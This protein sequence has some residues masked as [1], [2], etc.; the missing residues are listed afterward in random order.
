MPRERSQEDELEDDWP[1]NSSGGHA[2]EAQKMPTLSGFW[3]GGAEGDRTPDLLIANEALFP[4]SYRG[5]P[6]F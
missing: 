6:I 3:R 1:L 4:L 5:N 2:P